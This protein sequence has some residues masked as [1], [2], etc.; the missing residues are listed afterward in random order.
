MEVQK[1][2]WFDFWLTNCGYD[3]FRVLTANGVTSEQLDKLMEDT[4]QVGL[5][6]GIE[7]YE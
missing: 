3:V 4:A 5:G 1:S 7:R 6:K 2:F